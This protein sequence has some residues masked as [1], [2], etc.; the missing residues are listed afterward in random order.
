MP[1][2]SESRNCKDGEEGVYRDWGA[3]IRVNTVPAS[4]QAAG[5]S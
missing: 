3:L 2:C 5:V 1:P 4:C